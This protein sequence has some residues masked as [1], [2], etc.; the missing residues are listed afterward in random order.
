MKRYLFLVLI[1]IIALG[2]DIDPKTGCNKDLNYNCICS[3]DD[4]N[5]CVS[6]PSN[7]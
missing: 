7:Y 5:K 3:A 6:C 1:P 2:W 4:P